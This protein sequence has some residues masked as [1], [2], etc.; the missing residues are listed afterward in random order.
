[1]I[2]L[3][4][5]QVFHTFVQYNYF[6]KSIRKN[7]YEGN[8]MK[9]KNI[10]NN[11]TVSLLGP[12]ESISLIE[13]FNNVISLSALRR[14]QDKAQVFPLK[15]GDFVRTRLTHSIEVMSTADEIGS[16]IA[17]KLKEQ[18]IEKMMKKI[19]DD[20]RH[21]NSSNIIAEYAETVD[22]LDR[23]PQ[24]LKSASILHD[25]G[26]PPFGH[27][28]EEI[29]SNWFNQKLKT[30]YINHKTK[31]LTPIYS[32]DEIY[33]NKDFRKK[34]RR[35]SDILSTRQKNDLINFEGNAQLL[36]VLFKLNNCDK[37]FSAGV[38]GACMKY[39]CSSDNGQISKNNNVVWKK[40]IGYFISEEEYV[41]NVFD[42]IGSDGAR[43]PLAFI[44]EAADD[45]SY[46]LSDVEDA[47]KK[48]LLTYE[49]VY[50]KIISISNNSSNPIVEEAAEKI[51]NNQTKSKTEFE[52]MFFFKKVYRKYFINDVVDVFMKNSGSILNGQFTDE[53]LARG[54][55]IKVIKCLKSFLK[56]KVYHSPLIAVEKTK[57]H[58]ILNSL[59]DAFVPAS[60]L[61]EKTS[62]NKSESKH[63]MICELMSENYKAICKK[64]LKEIDDKNISPQ[65]KL[66]EKIYAA[67]RLAVDEIS[68]MTDYYALKLFKIINVTN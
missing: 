3:S 35:L 19:E 10:T 31:S 6:C 57:V 45:I 63:Q 60:F 37:G 32:F 26:N 17:S 59:L 67:L 14:L 44:L 39:T 25:M 11:E 12:S 4:L 50:Q 13:E 54:V 55:F 2:I 34:Y 49:E 7:V 21:A 47:I 51:R 18:E 41:K 20:K 8:K 58:T 1:M 15:T 42:T 68:G 29:I 52:K 5:E 48:K 28:G 30:F 36:R 23:I 16:L 43:S 9:W 46:L 33:E 22:I 38:V 66:A 53:L 64:E 62:S 61:V 56:N 27:I 40:K 65:A 24:I